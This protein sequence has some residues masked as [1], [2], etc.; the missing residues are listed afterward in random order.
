MP[1]AMGC[2]R[3]ARFTVEAWPVDYRAPRRLS[4]TQWN[5]SISEGL[6]RVDIVAREY[7]G[8]AVYYLAGR[9]DTVFPAP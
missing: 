6:R 9:I 4:L 1:R 3:R 7:V 8:L 2:F 5:R